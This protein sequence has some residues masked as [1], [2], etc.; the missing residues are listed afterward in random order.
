MSSMDSNLYALLP[1]CLQ[2]WMISA[3]YNDHYNLQG[4]YEAYYTNFE[5][6]LA[7]QVILSF[8]NNV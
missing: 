8:D 4:P 2:I 6:V 1:T 7:L 3:L 5:C